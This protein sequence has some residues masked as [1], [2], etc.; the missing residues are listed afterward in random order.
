VVKK[1]MGKSLTTTTLKDDV[2]AFMFN[3]KGLIG[4]G[5]GGASMGAAAIDSSKAG[6]EDFRDES[7]FL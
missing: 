5:L 6:K 1:G 7:S 4:V 3:Q 2:Y